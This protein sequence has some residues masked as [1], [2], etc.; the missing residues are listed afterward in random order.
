M[1]QLTSRTIFDN[2][3]YGLTQHTYQRL[4]LACICNLKEDER[5]TCLLSFRDRTPPVP[6]KPTVCPLWWSLPLCLNLIW[7]KHSPKFHLLWLCFF[8]TILSYFLCSAEDYLTH[9]IL[10][11]V[12]GNHTLLFLLQFIFFFLFLSYFCSFVHL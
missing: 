1:F 3:C 9:W 2:S 6:A 11:F 4:Y 7:Y 5:V 8:F 10:Q 12:L